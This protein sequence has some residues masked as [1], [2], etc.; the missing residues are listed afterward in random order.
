M[1]AA[2][3]GLFGDENVVRTDV[4]DVLGQMR[5]IENEQRVAAGQEPL[6]ELDVDAIRASL[7][8]LQS[9]LDEIAAQ[10]PAQTDVPAQAEP[11]PQQV[12]VAVRDGVANDPDAIRMQELVEQQPEQTF[13]F[14]DED[15]QT[16]ELRF[17]EIESEMQRIEIE[18]KTEASGIA[19]AAICIMRNDGAQ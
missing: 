1:R 14:E 15:G 6:P 11:N 18:G 17:D 13:L 12:Q 3:G 10:A 5:R 7:Q 2:D 9:Q 16:V 8:N 19:Q 4:A